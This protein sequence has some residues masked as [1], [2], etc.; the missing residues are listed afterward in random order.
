MIAMALRFIDFVIDRSAQADTFSRMILNWRTTIAVLTI[1]LTVL[2]LLA[3]S[4][5]KTNSRFSPY[6][7]VCHFLYGASRVDVRLGFKKYFSER[8][9]IISEKAICQLSVWSR[10]CHEGIR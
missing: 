4:K 9:A 8:A 10:T 2:L 7:I 3:L 6:S 1:C 5:D